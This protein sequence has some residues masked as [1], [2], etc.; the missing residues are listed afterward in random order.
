MRVHLLTALAVSIPLGLITAFLMSIALRARR[1][2]VVTGIQGLVGE[3]GIAQTPLS[4]EGKVFVHGELW[5]AVASANI[6]SGR[7]VVVRQVDGLQLQVDPAPSPQPD[8]AST[9]A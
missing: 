2:K 8:W 7:S 3:I 4:P 9:S 6:A 5:D 1:N